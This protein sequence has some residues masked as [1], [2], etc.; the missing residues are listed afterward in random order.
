MAKAEYTL[1]GKIADLANYLAERIEELSSSATLEDESD[2]IMNG[3]ACMVLI[4]ERYSYA[5][6]NRVSLNVTLTEFQ[7]VIRV[8][9]IT[10]GG[11]QAVFLKINTLGEKKFLD[12]FCCMIQEWQERGAES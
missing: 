1:R 12:V 5:G 9:A 2:W 4:F 10:S 11:S 3:V 8:S 7:G 6:Q